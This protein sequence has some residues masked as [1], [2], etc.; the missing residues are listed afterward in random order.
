MHVRSYKPW[1]RKEEQQLIQWRKEGTKITVISVKLQRT[2]ASIQK[3]LTQLKVKLV[4][5][6]YRYPKGV[7]QQKVLRL[8]QLNSPPTDI[9]EKLG[10]DVSYVSRVRRL[11]NIT[12]KPAVKR[13]RKVYPHRVKELLEQKKSNKEIAMILQCSKSRIHQIKRKLKQKCESI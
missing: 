4:S 10:V 1:T 13:P 11:F 12:A 7:L 5:K 2:Y 8:L 3:R 9:S 6:H